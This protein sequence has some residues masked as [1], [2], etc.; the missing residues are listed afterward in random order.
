VFA[1]AYPGSL[2]ERSARR[3][4]LR[5]LSNAVY[6]LPPFVISPDELHRVYHFILEAIQ[7]LF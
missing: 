4:A 5:P 6:V 2:F 3:A 1:A 7:T